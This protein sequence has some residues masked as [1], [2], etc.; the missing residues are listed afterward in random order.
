V[1]DPNQVY[2]TPPPSGPGIKIPILFGAVIALVAANIYL[3]LQLDTV[4][5]DIAKMRESILTEVA[6]LRE[7]SSVTTQTNRRHLDSLRDE[8]EAARRQASMAV[9]QAK[10]DA[11]K[12]TEDIQ[13][14]FEAE[15]KK[16]QQQVATQITEV[17]EAASATSA[18]L[19]E[20]TTEVGAVKSE[21]ASTKSELDKTIADLKRVTGDLGVTS[22]LV[23]TNGKE[24][25]ALKALGDRNI[26]E[27]KLGK[28]KAPQKV[29]DITMLLKKTDPKKNRYTIEVVADD[30]RVEKKDK[31]VNEPLQF[32]VARAPRQPYE[33]VVNEVK[34]DLIVGYLSTP[35]VQ[36]AR[37]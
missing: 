36:A 17:K 33:I 15:Q 37:N 35:K 27:F 24:I 13:R 23:A 11:D 12:R 10:A 9:G 18:K 19:G 3:Y 4:R 26:F 14:R 32:I 7:T 21:V 20:V 8:L 25:M 29:G 2:L 30:K 16:V 5:T 31:N 28:T 34:K 6:N 1:S 22:G